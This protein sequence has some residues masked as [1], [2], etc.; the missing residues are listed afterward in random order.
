MCARAQ[1]LQGPSP[2]VGEPRIPELPRW[3]CP[4]VL[5]GVTLFHSPAR[6]QGSAQV[7]SQDSLG[8]GWAGSLLTPV[9]L[10]CPW[11]HTVHCQGMEGLW[12]H[13]VLLI[14]LL[15]CP[16]GSQSSSTP[17]QRWWTDPSEAPSQHQAAR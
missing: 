17:D 7:L 13:G 1:R 15:P 3:G 4:Q 11:R 16:V 5:T 2:R 6:T 12:V 8:H 14:F 10:S 9:P